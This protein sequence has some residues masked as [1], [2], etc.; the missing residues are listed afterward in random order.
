MKKFLVNAECLLT[1]IL[2]RGYVQAEVKAESAEEVK[3][4]LNSKERENL[5]WEIKITDYDLDYYSTISP[6]E[7]TPIDNLT[8]LNDEINRN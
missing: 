6:Y 3:K 7:I 1:G 2:Q 5:D 4:I 8:L